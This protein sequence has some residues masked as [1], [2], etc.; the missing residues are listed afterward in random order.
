MKFKRKL[1]R[2]KELG[3]PIL[4][5]KTEEVGDIKSREIQELIDKMMATVMEVN[6]VGISAPQVGKSLQVFIMAS[7]PNPRYPKAPKMKPTAII[8]PKII[9]Y[10]KIIK[11]AWEGCLSIPGLRGLVPRSKT[12]KVEYIARTSQKVKKEFSGFL[13]RIFQHEFDHLQGMMFIDR[14]ESMLDLMSEKEW[15]K[16][17]DNKT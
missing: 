2:I 4:R 17:I 1:L 15:K 5:K 9:K 8:N 11:K 6:G 14:V 3:N 10:G 13:A 12:V 16:L 7:H